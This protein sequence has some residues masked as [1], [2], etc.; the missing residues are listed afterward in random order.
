MSYQP[1][2]KTKEKPHCDSC[3]VL[4]PHSCAT[5]KSMSETGIDSW[6]TADPRPFISL[7]AT[8]S[9]IVRGFLVKLPAV[10]LTADSVVLSVMGGI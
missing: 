7:D 2:P 4:S 6:P 9:D 3:M 10:M 5:R 8:V 1:H